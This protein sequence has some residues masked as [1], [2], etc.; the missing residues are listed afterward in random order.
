[1]SIRAGPARWHNSA[2]QLHQGRYEMGKRYMLVLTG[3]GTVWDCGT[4]CETSHRRER[5]KGNDF[6]TLDE[7]QESRTR[8]LVMVMVTVMTG[9][10]EDLRKA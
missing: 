5:K 9:P 7:D 8:A 1:M 2:A 10:Q 3:P 6:E 4:K